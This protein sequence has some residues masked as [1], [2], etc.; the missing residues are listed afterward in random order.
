MHSLTKKMV[1]A[2]LLGYPTMVF[3]FNCQSYGFIKSCEGIPCSNICPPHSDGF[4]AKKN[5][6]ASDCTNVAAAPY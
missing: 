3:S 6:V 2:L 4:Y 5:C 1:I